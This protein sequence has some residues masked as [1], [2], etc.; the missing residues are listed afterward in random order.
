MVNVCGI[1]QT[2]GGNTIISPMKVILLKTE[3]VEPIVA[4]SISWAF[5]KNSA[6]WYQA[7][8]Y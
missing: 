6:I 3:I 2:L 4:D 7:S 1:K 8:H 5:D